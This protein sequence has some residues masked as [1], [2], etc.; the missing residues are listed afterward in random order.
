MEFEGTNSLATLNVV[1][2][3]CKEKPSI[4]YNHFINL[5]YSKFTKMKTHARSLR[6]NNFFLNE[7][8]ETGHLRLLIGTLPEAKKTPSHELK[9]K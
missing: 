6:V 3:T 2:K 1:T 5:N 9:G 4:G 8:E 7:V